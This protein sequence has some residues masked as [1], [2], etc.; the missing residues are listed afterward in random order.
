MKL[1][2]ADEFANVIRNK[3]PLSEWMNRSVPKAMAA[4]GRFIE[5]LDEQ[6][7]MTWDTWHYPSEGDF[8]PLT[9]QKS[10]SDD[11]LCKCI[12]GKYRIGHYVNTMQNKHGTHWDNWMF[13]SGMELKYTVYKWKYIE[14]QG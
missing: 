3:I 9:N 1:I 8:P 2:D 4:M 7:P 6:P 14:I 13:E 11:V 10:C 5:K 12:D